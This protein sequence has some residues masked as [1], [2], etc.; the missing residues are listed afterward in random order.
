MTE[1]EINQHLWLHSVDTKHHSQHNNMETKDMTF[2]QCILSYLYDV[3]TTTPPTCVGSLRMLCVICG[4]AAVCLILLSRW[5]TARRAPLPHPWTV[6]STMTTQQHTMVASFYSPVTPIT[7]TTTTTVVTPVYSNIVCEPDVHSD[8][9]QENREARPV[10]YEPIIA[11]IDVPQPQQI[12]ASQDLQGLQPS[13]YIPQ[14]APQQS[15]EATAMDEIQ[16]NDNHDKKRSRESSCQTS[17]QP[18]PHHPPTRPATMTEHI[19]EASLA[20]SDPKK[21]KMIEPAVAA[22]PGDAGVMVLMPIVASPRHSDPDVNPVITT[23]P[24]PVANPVPSTTEQ[25]LRD[26]RKSSIPIDSLLNAVDTPTG[27]KKRRKSGH[28]WTRPRKRP[29]A[30]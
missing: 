21:Q 28:G 10:A 7:S 4:I 29:S 13:P 27:V 19:D 3:P 17:V 22:P 15:H 24:P 30:K 9:V 1:W 20:P 5:L 26:A 16:P 12:P 6:T 2:V 11:R 18:I 8:V 23:A 14:D 25:A